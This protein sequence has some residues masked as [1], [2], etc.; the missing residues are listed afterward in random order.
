MRRVKYKKNRK[1]QPNY[2]EYSGG[3][4]DVLIAMQLFVYD[5]NHY[6]EYND[7]TL[8]EI[9]EI[10]QNSSPTATK[11]FNL[12]GLHDI[13]LLKAIGKVFEIEGYLIAEV[14]N[15]SRRTRMEELDDTI[16]FSVKSILAHED[17]ESVEIEQISFILKDNLLLSFQEKKGDIF[18]LVRERIRTKTGSVRKKSNEFLLF[19]LLEAIMENFFITMD[20]IEDTIEEVLIASKASYKRNVL[21]SIERNIESLNYIKRAIIP[22]RDVLFNL[23]SGSSDLDPKFILP[24]DVIYFTRLHYRSLELLDQIEYNL[25]KMESAT[26]YF[27]S[28]QSHRMNEIMK[29]LT[30][31]S[32]IFIPLTFIVG[33]YGMNFDNMPELHYENGYF[34]TMF[35]MF[36]LV[37]FMVGYFKFKKWF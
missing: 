28:A 8:S 36:I 35:V 34:A 33:V 18:S 27:F 20:N 14:L 31:V 29:V 17:I 6:E 10:V 11:W 24:T 26:N 16:F 7:L 37:L 21:E 22:L 9:H 19:L 12:H 25:S 15:F 13:E 2:L 1:L 23:K 5:E 30:I 3:Y 32:V 4:P